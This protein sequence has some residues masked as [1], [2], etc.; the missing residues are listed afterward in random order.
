LIAQVVATVS[1]AIDAVVVALLVRF[2]FDLLDLAFIHSSTAVNRAAK[3]LVSIGA[4][5]T[6]GFISKSYTMRFPIL[7]VLIHQIISSF[8]SGKYISLF[9]PIGNCQAAFSP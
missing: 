4:G 8:A 5:L 1:V 3:S 6:R 9:D 7:S 2:A